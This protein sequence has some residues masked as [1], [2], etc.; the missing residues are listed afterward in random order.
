MSTATATATA[1]AE[2]VAVEGVRYYVGD[3]IDIRRGTAPVIRAV[4]ES[5][6]V[7]TVGTAGARGIT[8]TE[9]MA[10]GGRGWLFAEFGTFRHGAPAAELHTVN[11]DDRFIW[12]DEDGAE[13]VVEIIVADD[14]TGAHL[15]RVVSTADGHTFGGGY[16][17]VIPTAELIRRA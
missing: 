13:F 8:A 7:H 16:R 14:Y 4:V 5:V 17:V 15:A 1:T 2:Y 9:E 11:P 10:N 3:A 12:A 6:T